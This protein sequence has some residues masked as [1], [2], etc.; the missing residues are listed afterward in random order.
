MNR[1]T[2]SRRRAIRSFVRRA[3]RMTPSQQ[4]ALDELWPVFGIESSTTPVDFGTVF[5]REAPVVLEIGF[6]N[7]D[8]LVQQAAEHPDWDFVGIE[9]H[10]PGVGHCLLRAQDTGVTNLRLI[11]H[12]AVEVL[13]EQ[14]PAASLSRVNLY[15]PDPWPKKRHHK[16]RIVQAPFLDL[17][18]E[19]L[20][21]GGALHI[22]T[23]WA[24]YAEHIDEVINDCGR[25]DCVE[26]REH[27]GDRALDR[28]QTKFER[29]GLTKGHRIRDWKF[30][31]KN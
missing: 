15:F 12:D 31:R 23:D 13:A 30:V 16:R 10:E 7:G 28:P 4:R 29:R 27:N 19:R 1:Q 21:P 3:G 26:D 18:A 24:N 8:T 22:A 2:G 11:S 6:G 20:Q 5:G 25:F 17:V 14:V 9:V